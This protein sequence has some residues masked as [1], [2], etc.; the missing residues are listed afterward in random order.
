MTYR[1]KNILNA[2][3]AHQVTLLL[4]F[5]SLYSIIE[6]EKEMGIQIQ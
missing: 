6:W 3:F 1:I 2:I 4:Y 5:S